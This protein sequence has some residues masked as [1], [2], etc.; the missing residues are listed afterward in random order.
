MD[1]RKMT[2]TQLIDE[3]QAMGE[4]VRELERRAK[5]GCLAGGANE[6]RRLLG[7]MQSSNQRL[8]LL[9]ETASSLLRSDSPQHIVD[10]LCHKVLAV[11]DCQTF[12]NYLVDY[13]KKRLRL[14]AYGGIPEEDAAKMEWLDYGVGLCGCAARDGRRLVVENLQE[15]DDQYSA[16][17]RPFGITAYACHALVSKGQ[18]LGTLSFC[19]RNRNTFSEDELSLMQA[20]ADQVAIALYRKQI[21]EKLKETNADL[22]KRVAER[23]GELAAMVDKLQQEILERERAE[24]ELLTS[25]ERYSLAIDGASGGL[26][27]IDLVTG[28]VFYSQRWKS[29]LGYRDEEVLPSIEEWKSR[30]HPDDQGHVMDSRRVYLEGLT[31]DYEVKYRLLHKNGSYRWVRERGA[32]LRDAQGKP[33][34]MA[35]SFID[36]TERKMMKN[37]LLETEKRYRE[38]F[39]QSKDTVFIVDTRGRL[40]DINPAGSELLGYSREELFA[41]DL[42]H[43]LHVSRQARADFRHK[44]IPEGFVK[45]AELEL[46]RKDGGTVIVHVSASL[47]H[48]GRGRLTGYR[49]IAYDV[50]ERKR[51]EQ[52]LLQSQKMESIGLLAGGVAHE[53]N[54]LLT[55]IIGFADELQ[56][57][58][59]GQDERSRS[60]VRTIRSAARQAAKFTR[61][62]LSFSR[63]QVMNRRPVAVNEVINDTVKLL[64]K[65]F[66]KDIGF[67][68]DLAV[69]MPTVMADS[70]QLGQVLMNLAIN[71]RDSMPG[72]GEIRITT[73]QDR[74]DLDSARS[75]GLEQPGDY[76]VIS[77]SDSGTGMDAGTLERLFEPFFTTKDVGKG[78][79]LGLSIVYGIIRQHNGAILVESTPGKGTAFLIYLPR[80]K[81]ESR[82]E[83]QQTAARP[84]DGSGT[85]LI[86]EDEEFVRHFLKATLSRAGYQFICA[87]DGEQALKKYRKHQETIS[88]VISDMVMPKMNG[89]ALFE[90]LCKINPDI[91]MILISGFSADVIDFTG[92]PADRMRFI[93]KPFSKKALFDAM[94]AMLGRD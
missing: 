3:L 45:D 51:L 76:L 48:D 55:A 35:G 80:V 43:D 90:E 23:T 25:Q 56:E 38:L 61:G 41:L 83:Y 71:A 27:D 94:N 57:S 37:A 10:S 4:R 53:F 81:T 78:T 75:I 22:E 21:E 69:E 64:L 29:M 47:M 42:V 28:A 19:A 74:L 11:L 72:G 62:L 2:K 31:P 33:Y 73:R 54:N 18:V 68:L 82:P 44:L 63:Q 39:E 26:W 7:E 12:F 59:D 87:G 46:K 66:P 17:V 6:R 52:R 20:V 93:T 49:G 88:L 32:C 1:P 70:G 65:M 92:M 5:N 24:Q 15:T 16:L 36:I 34:R 14:N 85:V 9:A 58:L 40:V 13:D 8:D 79:G 84:H 77:F 60:N 86:A 67:S 91:K 30:I 50:T 89:R